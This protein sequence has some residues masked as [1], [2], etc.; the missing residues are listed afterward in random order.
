MTSTAFSA[1]ISF[2]RESPSSV[3]AAAALAAYLRAAIAATQTTGLNI[4]CDLDPDSDLLSALC[5][6]M[7]ACI[8]LCPD[9]VASAQCLAEAVAALEYNIPV[10]VFSLQ[11]LPTNAV[12]TACRLSPAQTAHLDLLHLPDNVMQFQVSVLLELPRLP[13]PPTPDAIAALV[14]LLP[15]AAV[16]APTTAILAP[17]APKLHPH[18]PGPHPVYR[19]LLSTPPDLYDLLCQLDDDPSHAVPLFYQDAPALLMQLLASPNVAP[20]SAVMCCKLLVYLVAP[21]VHRQPL[22]NM[23]LAQTLTT[24][25]D[26]RSA[27]SELAAPCMQVLG[28]LAQ[29]AHQKALCHLFPSKQ[30]AHA[31]LAVLN[32]HAQSPA[33]CTQ[34]VFALASIATLTPSCVNVP[35]QMPAV[36]HTLTQHLADK[37]IAESLAQLL[38]ALATTLNVQLQLVKLQAHKVLY[39]I[40]C[41]HA[42]DPN[43]CTEAC[44]AAERLATPR[45]NKRAMFDMRLGTVVIAAVRH[46][47]LRKDLCRRG[48]GALMQ[49]A[50]DPRNAGDLFDM[51]AASVV[52]EVLSMNQTKHEKP[53]FWAMSMWELSIDTHENLSRFFFGAQRLLIENSKRRAS[54]VDINRQALACLNLMANKRALAVPLMRKGIAKA[55]VYAARA[56]AADATV[57]ILCCEILCKLALAPVNHD[58]LVQLGAARVAEDT[59]ECRAGDPLAVKAAQDV[60]WHLDMDLSHWRPLVDEEGNASA[61]VEEGDLSADLYQGEDAAVDE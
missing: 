43:V 46:W 55:V 59:I 22:L 33:I 21:L 31:I 45:A 37:S 41:K 23:P 54:A 19:Q 27:W 18:T 17:L 2:H 51:G 30:A 40:L 9:Y 14:A 28:V 60:L 11:P 39:D 47:T 15:T 57:T 44:W 38:R 4:T 12:T 5:T 32:T 1:F 53:T 35:L 48:T 24:L 3:A 16:P 20:S 49:L 10:R 29:E 36:L 34:A 56:F 61:P 26:T 42:K 25:L 52:A 8:L 7:F 50:Q 13:F 6:S 58:A